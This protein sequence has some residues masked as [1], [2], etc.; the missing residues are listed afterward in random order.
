M[1]RVLIIEDDRLVR[2]GLISALPWEEHDMKVVAEAGN[3][4]QGLDVLEA[5]TIDLVITDI[6]MPVMNGLDMMAEMQD[7]QLQVP[8]VLLTLHEEFSY[9]QRALRM[10]AIDYISKTEINEESFAA[11]L[12]RINQRLQERQSHELPGTAKRRLTSSE[13]WALLCP[14]GTFSELTPLLKET[15]PSATVD[16]VWFWEQQLSWT[17]ESVVEE[18]RAA[19]I[20]RN[21]FGQ[22]IYTTDIA[23][24]TL[25]TATLDLKEYRDGLGFYEMGEAIP[26]VHRSEADVSIVASPGRAAKHV[27]QPLRSMDWL[28]FDHTMDQLKQ[29]LMENGISTEVLK[30][31][32]Y[33][34]VNEWNRL[35]GALLPNQ[36]TLPSYDCWECL[37]KWLN[38]IKEIFE[39]SAGKPQLSG[40]VQACIYQAVHL[41]HEQIGDALHASELAKRV[42]MS[43]SYFSQCFK[44]ITGETF[45]EYVRRIR[46]DQ[47]KVY[48]WQTEKPVS[49]VAGEVGYADQKY[50]SRVFRETTGMLPSEYRRKGDK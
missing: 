47:A 27:L 21:A 28:R 44:D 29:A 45:N 36:L 35:Y 32:M 7:R 14:D 41:V 2:K 38:Y 24:W 23:N 43:R 30:Q 25:E 26:F 22:I 1:I 19:A 34:I 33:A 39:Q 37:E 31:E 17:Q 5:E 10:G 20:S 8:V 40:E 46:M 6:S 18:L 50:F 13:G 42:N 49:W 3:G 9:V 48:L 11:L 4:Q 12:Q 15:A 16:G